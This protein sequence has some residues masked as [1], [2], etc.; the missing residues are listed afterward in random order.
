MRGIRGRDRERLRRVVLR[1]VG[2]A[3]S[4]QQFGEP[5]TGLGQAGRQLD[6]LLQDLDRLPRLVAFRQ[7]GTQSEIPLRIRRPRTD[8]RAIRHLRL[9]LAIHRRV[10]IA[11]AGVGIGVRRR[12]GQNRLELLESRVGLVSGVFFGFA[13]GLGGVGAAAMGYIAD[14][15]GIAFVYQLCSYL[16]ALGLV[17]W[18]LPNLETKP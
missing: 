16:P 11:Q 5:Q 1:L 12:Q 10:Q 6:G 13:F 7:H 18:L 17:A 2:L 4:H 8:E 3:K 9:G 15:Q 14:A